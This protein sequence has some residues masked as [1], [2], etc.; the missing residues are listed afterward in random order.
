MDFFRS[1]KQKASAT[2]SVNEKEPVSEPVLVVQKDYKP[3][4]PSP[5]DDTQQQKLTQLREYINTILLPET[6][7]YY[8]NE[9]GFLTDATLHRYMRARKWDYEAAKTMLE[10]TIHWRRDFKP[11]LLDPNYIKPEAETGKMYW[12][13][14]DHAGRP[15]WV[16]RPRHQNSKDN[17]RQIKHIVFC[18]ER[19]IRLM[20]KGVET[21]DII[22]DFKGA[23]AAHHP[24]LST[25]KKFLE[26]L[27]NHYPERL[28]YA[29]IVKSPWF[30]L[31]SFK[32]ISPFIDPVTRSKIK[33]VVEK[34][35]EKG[36]GKRDTSELAYLPDYIPEDQIETEFYGDLNFK[37]DIDIYWTRLLALTGNPHKVIDY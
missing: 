11:D 24:S 8:P 19:G 17:E 31:T 29:F 14:F 2:P 21:I 5:L 37:F 36:D 9:K 4:I 33:F 25:S 15:V 18:L 1:G 34:K 13:C 6:D 20:P 10:N 32:L 30:F 12:N 16:M 7:D 23:L 28:G 27:S 35:D 3:I 22:I 26:I